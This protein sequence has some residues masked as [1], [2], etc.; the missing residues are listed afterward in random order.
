MSESFTVSGAEPW[1][2]PHRPQSPIQRVVEGRL[3]AGGHVRIVGDHPRPASFGLQA[4]E[5]RPRRAPF[6]PRAQAS[7]LLGVLRAQAQDPAQEQAFLR[8]AMAVLA[9]ALT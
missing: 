4:P 8:Q 9:E 6:D 2:L 5:A 1:D 7:L 3:I